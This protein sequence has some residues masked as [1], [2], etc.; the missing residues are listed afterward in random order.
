MRSSHLFKTD[1]ALA[2]TQRILPGSFGPQVCIM[3]N[4]DRWVPGVLRI[5]RR[6]S[7]SAWVRRSARGMLRRMIQLSWK[8]FDEAWPQPFENSQWMWSF[9]RTVE[10]AK[11]LVA[12]PWRSIS[13][14][15]LT[16]QSVITHKKRLVKETIVKALEEIREQNLRGRI[17]LVADKYSSHHA[18]LTSGKGRRTRHRVRLHSAVLTDVERD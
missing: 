3:P 18:I 8:S 13:F 12:V 7:P 4:R 9:D 16:G 14:Y 2:I 17:L 10:I 5:L 15:A 6:Y 1:S 11:L